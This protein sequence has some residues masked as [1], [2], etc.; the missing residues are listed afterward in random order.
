ML[1]PLASAQSGLAPAQQ[2]HPRVA[3][4]LSGGGARGGAHLGVLKVLEELQ[5]PVD[6]VV[7]TS[8]G[9]IVGAAYATGMP[10][11][12]IEREL[13]AVRTSDLFHDVARTDLPLRLRDADRDNL[14]GLEVGIGRDGAQ[15]PIGVVAGVSMEAVLR[16]LA[17]RQRSEDFDAFPMPFRAVATDMASAQMVV[18]D[19]GSLA[20]AMRASM[21]LPALVDPVELDGR[22]L[23]DGGISRNL[24][25]DVARSLGADVVIA[26]NVGSPLQP[27]DK[28]TSVVRIT[29]QLTRMLTTTN[30]AASLAQLGQADVLIAPR[31]TDLSMI[32]FD[33]VPEAVRAGELAARAAA[34]RLARLAVGADAYRAFQAARRVVPDAGQR[35]VG[36]DV[37]GTQR[38]STES[39]RAALSA[40]EGAPFDP[41]AT[42]RDMRRLYGTG[43]FERVDYYL[44]DADGGR[45]LTATVSEKRWGPNYVRAGLGL[46][47]DF[48][49]DAQFNAVLAHRMTGLNRL[50]GEWSN[51]L[52]IGRTELLGTEFHQPFAFG[53]V[54]FGAVRGELR[55][56]PFD[57]FLQQQRIGRY[58]R[59]ERSASAEVGAQ[60][61]TNAEIRV[62]M[63]GAHYRLST[64]TGIISGESLVPGQGMRGISARL[65]LDT[66]DSARF[67]R[68]GYAADL[69]YLHAMT[70]GPGGTHYGKLDLW[71]QAAA[72]AGPHTLRAA[73][74]AIRP[75]GGRLPF[76]ELSQLGGFLRLSGY[77]TG[78]LLGQQAR[79][80]RLV[81]TY[82]LRAPGL[83]DGS[84]LGLSAEAGHIDD[85]LQSAGPRRA[86]RSNAAFIG[87]DTLLGPVYLGYGRAAGGSDALYLFLG[88]P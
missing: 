52:Q 32:D 55:R 45:R 59:I 63:M 2:A 15:L 34:P 85:L 68:S 75:A 61:G 66:L 54:W 60:L 87:T 28:L 31:M 77:R 5:I 86:L 35:I 26:V 78:E 65:R 88:V 50:G 57:L 44:R 17:S 73:A 22:L 64:D 7:G 70:D 82:R 13:A 6:L 9:A 41:A 30:T 10:L 47:T 62:G 21:A 42:E 56:E 67:P 25:V 33:R 53:G 81:Y 37:T 14:V 27:R 69:R 20:T 16:R 48:H 83:W 72:S 58:R 74:S 76:Y 39:V 8:A 71:A 4:V 3:L 40:R 36:V 11:E 51:R 18:L 79:F 38:V 80:G 46:S 1:A 49:G 84:Y 23:V 24:P 43:A 19:H 12:D 29:E